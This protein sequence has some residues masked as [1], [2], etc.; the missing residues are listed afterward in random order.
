VLVFFGDETPFFSEKKGVL[1]K[2][3]AGRVDRKRI[4]IPIM[5]S[6]PAPDV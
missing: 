4:L 2:E 1:K 3:G 6:L 5:S